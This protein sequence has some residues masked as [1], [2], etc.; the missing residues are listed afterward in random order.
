MSYRTAH[1]LVTAFVLTWRRKAHPFN[2]S[3]TVPCPACGG[4]L[5]LVQLTEYKNAC[6]Q[7]SANCS[8]AFC[9][10]YTE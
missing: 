8:T 9:V 10:H 6:N 7:V 5:H 1:D 2:Q 4:K 3:E